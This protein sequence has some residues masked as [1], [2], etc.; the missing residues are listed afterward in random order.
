MQNRI[1][2]GIRIGM[3]EAL[4]LKLDVRFGILAFAGTIK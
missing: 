4:I 1:D 3:V 2:D